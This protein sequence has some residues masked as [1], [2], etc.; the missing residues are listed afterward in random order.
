[1]LTELNTELTEILVR[2]SETVPSLGVSNVGGWHSQYSLHKRPEP[3]FKKLNDLIIECV[4]GTS[5]LLAKSTGRKFPKVTT[6]SEMWAMVM[7]DGNYTIPHTHAD[8]HWASVYYPDCGDADE[9]QHADSGKITFVD[10]RMGV[11]PV[12]GLNMALAN[13]VVNPKPGQ[14]MI[15][16]GWL[17]HYVHP[18]RG[19]RP[20]VSVACNVSLFPVST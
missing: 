11:L 18:Y 13:Y 2:E 1:M 3:C 5:E 7:R 6:T 16:P 4:L 9:A 20:R 15:F 14:L 10:P 12:P 19:N 17:T 8:S